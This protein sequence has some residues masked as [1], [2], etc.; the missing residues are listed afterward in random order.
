MS[1]GVRSPAG[2]RALTGRIFEARLYDRALTPEE[3]AA[4]SSGLLLEVVTAEKIAKALNDGQRKAVAELDSRI[5]K[6]EAT[7]GKL[8]RDIDARR[9]A[10]N[11]SGD[12]YFRIAH[13]LLNSK[14]LIYVY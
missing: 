11:A 1:S 14:E 7:L 6:V 8:D 5:S 12:P 4:A 9:A 13:A 10:Q 3:V 2:N